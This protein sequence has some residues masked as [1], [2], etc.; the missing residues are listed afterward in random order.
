MIHPVH[1]YLCPLWPLF[2]YRNAL[3][4]RIGA[5]CH[6]GTYVWC[7]SGYKQSMHHEVQWNWVLGEVG[8]GIQL[9]RLSVVSKASLRR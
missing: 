2:K 7:I 5:A 1:R 8:K 3:A 6:P 9:S 4:K